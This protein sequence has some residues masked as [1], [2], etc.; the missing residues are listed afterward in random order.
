[1]TDETRVAG[2]L[3]AA[4]RSSRF[5]E[6]NKLLADLDG[7]PLVRHPAGTLCRADLRAVA[8]VVDPDSA[9]PDALSEFDLAVVPNPDAGAGQSASVRRGVEWARG[10][11]DAVLFALGDMPVVDRATVDRLV[12]AYRSGA[13][14]AV[15][16][17][18]DGQR[19]NPVLFD[20]RHF[21]ALARVTG[22]TGGRAVFRSADDSA[23]V[24]TGDP[25]VLVDVDAPADL[26]AL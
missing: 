5:G 9:V 1:M 17:G 8:A 16:A 20:G 22:D 25:G 14:S 23:V 7:E 21:D 18:Y 2:V 6:R 13:G 12:E 10:R 24:D 11:C 3:L 15:A 19:G 4:G 26:D